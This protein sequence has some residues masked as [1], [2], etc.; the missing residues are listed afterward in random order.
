MKYDAVKSVLLLSAVGAAAYLA[1]RAYSTGAGALG[2]VGSAIGNAAGTVGGWVNPAADTNLAYRGVNAVGG[3]LAGP[4]GAGANADG[5]WS[6]GG[7]LFDVFNP[8]IAAARDAVAGP[9][10]YS[11]T[12]INAVAI[13][14]AR[15]ID[16]IMERQAA[17]H[18]ALDARYAGAAWG[19]SGGASGVW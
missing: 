3:A 13:N 14:D 10:V 1:W 7:Y 2:S 6:L 15:Q 4:T 19:S 12:V 5:S 8:D 17:E 11:G 9:N 18:A 16:R